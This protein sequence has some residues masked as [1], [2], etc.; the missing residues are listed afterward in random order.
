[1]NIF[2][3]SKE[4]INSPILNK[5]VKDPSFNKITKMEHNKIENTSCLFEKIRNDYQQKKKNKSYI[6]S[7]LF[8]EG[9]QQLL[10]SIISD[11]RDREDEEDSN[12]DNFE[13]CSFD[14]FK[15]QF[16]G[17]NEKECDFFGSLSFE[18]SVV[19]E[20]AGVV[21]EIGD[22]GSFERSVVLHGDERRASLGG[23]GVS[24]GLGVSGSQG[25]SLGSRERSLGG[26]GVPGG[27]G[28]FLT[29]DERR[30][31]SN[32]RRRSSDEQTT[33]CM[34]NNERILGTRN[35][36]QSFRTGSEQNDV[37]Y[38]EDES[39]ENGRIADDDKHYKN[40][41][42]HKQWISNDLN[43][44]QSKGCFTYTVQPAPPNNPFNRRINDQ[45][46]T[47]GSISADQSFSDKNIK[48]S[49][50]VHER[51]N[52]MQHSPSS[53]RRVVS[54]R[55]KRTLREEDGSVKVY[56]NKKMRLSAVRKAAA[57]EHA[58]ECVF[59]DERRSTGRRVLKVVSARSLKIKLKVSDGGR[60]TVFGGECLGPADTCGEKRTLRNKLFNLRRE[61]L[62][63][64]RKLTVNS[65][66]N[67][68]VLSKHEQANGSL[69]KFTF[70]KDHGRGIFSTFDQL[71]GREAILSEFKK[72]NSTAILSGFN[73]EDRVGRGPVVHNEFNTRPRVFKKQGIFLKESRPK[74]RKS[75]KI[76]IKRDR[77][78]YQIEFKDDSSILS[79]NDKC[80]DE[81]VPCRVEKMLSEA[82]LVNILAPKTRYFS[83]M[84]FKGVKKIAEAS[85]SDVYRFKDKIYKIIPF[86]EYY[87]KEEFLREVYVLRTLQNEKYVIKLRNF[88]V[89]KGAYNQHLHAAWDAYARDHKSEN[90]RPN[91]DGKNGE[92]GCLVMDDAGTDL[93]NY[94]FKKMSDILLF[95]KIII[96]CLSVLEFKYQF[97]HRD[98]HW[99][100]ILI[101][102]NNMRNDSLCAFSENVRNSNLSG[103]FVP[104]DSAPFK[105]S[106]IDF[107]L[108]RFSTDHGVV[109]K[110]LS[111]EKELFQGTGDEQ[112]D[113][114]RQMKRIC[115]NDWSKF[116]PITNVLWLKYLVG[117]L[118][119]K[120]LSEKMCNMVMR[121]VVSSGSATELA[122][123]MQS[124]L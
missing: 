98:L 113:V 103:H 65:S 42:D 21:D 29:R 123:Q 41:L 53:C 28:M 37:N 13:F 83:A 79:S 55:L 77:K 15:R 19:L 38:G 61:E 58:D 51:I 24:G 18:K 47:N 32:E 119:H 3:L 117:K 20:G 14:H 82:E 104:E 86:T 78:K 70:G 17:E 46:T 97:E 89:C 64:N 105:V 6:Q 39:R 33:I 101:Q 99:G 115:C 45:N 85:F 102:H 2:N 91:S 73:K 84:N 31:S 93:E 35:D 94:Q 114:Y 68:D 81:N 88:F 118:R 25:V 66:Q 9:I 67:N 72:Q 5:M 74:R 57:D 48:Q 60:K 100:N 11:N 75:L 8:S 34:T 12:V 50:N 90:K 23:Q 1:M 62:F 122:Q 120:G 76:N 96:E 22:E 124:I 63:L 40:I 52:T 107:G 111:P 10:M 7:T 110:D 108:S 87:T 71:Q 43:R 27:Q 26:Q 30:I 4:I 54:V 36:Q 109:Y 69:R 112:Y 95:L 106:I 49:K 80:P 44:W 59:G 16:R 116:N 121:M 56:K 92:Y